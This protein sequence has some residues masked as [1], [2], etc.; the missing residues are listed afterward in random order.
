MPLSAVLC[1]RSLR[2]RGFGFRAGVSGSTVCRVWVLRQGDKWRC[3]RISK[4]KRKALKALGCS[5]LSARFH[6]GSHGAFEACGE[7]CDCNH[8]TV[9]HDSSSNSP[10]APINEGRYVR[11]TV[12]EFF[13]KATSNLQK[14]QFNDGI[15]QPGEPCAAKQLNWC[16]NTPSRR[17]T[18]R[19]PIARTKRRTRTQTLKTPIESKKPLSS[20]V[21]CTCSCSGL[22]L[23]VFVAE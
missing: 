18:R 15:R 2:L 3:C 4:R 1:F 19:A 16:L 7:R 14:N 10:Q 21:S 13:G 9:P 20:K 5:K 8:L 17:I 6:S 23:H 11:D 12:P 22:F